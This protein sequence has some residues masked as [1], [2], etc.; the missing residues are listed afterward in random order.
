MLLETATSFPGRIPTYV[1]RPPERLVETRF[2]GPD[3]PILFMPSQQCRGQF[4]S[5]GHRLNIVWFQE[6]WAPP[7]DPTVLEELGRSTSWPS[8]STRWVPGEAPTATSCRVDPVPTDC[9]SLREPSLPSSG[10][11]TSASIVVPTRSAETAWSSSTE[12][13]AS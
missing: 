3:G 12:A 5:G 10:P 11:S 4:D 9:R 1:V 8:P 6:D 2:V 7:M 13:A